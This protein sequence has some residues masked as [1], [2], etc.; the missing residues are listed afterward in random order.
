MKTWTRFQ[1]IIICEIVDENNHFSFGFPMKI[2]YN[3][4]IREPILEND[5][6]SIGQILIEK[7]TGAELGQLCDAHENG[8]IEDLFFDTLYPVDKKNYPEKYACPE[9]EDV[10]CVDEESKET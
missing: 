2:H 7:L 3:L 1:Q 9:D 8:S 5:M 10:R 4:N 6:C